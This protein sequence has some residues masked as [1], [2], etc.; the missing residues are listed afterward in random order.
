MV[1]SNAWGR[2]AVVALL[3]GA[4]AG[5]G[6]QD[7]PVDPLAQGV[8]AGPSPDEVLPPQ[9]APPKTR[10]AL[11]P[12]TTPAADAM[13]PEKAEKPAEPLQA[14]RRDFRKR[15]KQPMLADEVAQHASAIL[16]Y[17]ML[18]AVVYCDDLYQRRKVPKPAA[19]GGAATAPDPVSDS[20]CDG[21]FAAADHGWSRLHTYASDRSDDTADL[22]AGREWLGLRFGVFYRPEADGSVSVAV[23]F[24]GTDF[25]SLAD[26]YSN[27]R[28]VLPGHD[29]YNQVSDM[30][31]Q[32]IDRT[33]LD[34]KEALGRPIDRWHIVSTGHS[35]G[36]GLAQLFAYRS[37]EVE[38]AVVFDPSPVTAYWSCV[39]PK[40]LHCNVPV[41]RI[42]EKGEALAYVR[43]F[44]R[45]FYSLSENITE[46]EFDLLHGNI[47]ANHSMPR[48]YRQL[49]KE[50][51]ARPVAEDQF[52]LLTKGHPDCYC[53]K[54]IN[55]V[56]WK[57]PA[58]EQCEKLYPPSDDPGADAPMRLS[59]SELGGR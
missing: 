57:D 38:A 13:L 25:T 47:I 36:G 45:L 3:L 10:G 30:V 6:A 32:V 34:I 24:R 27:L 16:P 46:L 28:W 8:E 31:E 12:P 2:A 33:K 5:A 44:L 48:F 43:S 39:D 21:G 59:S 15:T 22:P 50:V 9:D 53:A 19:T 20:D 56:W 52:A 29:Q 4:A 11:D 1:I 37:A 58:K 49:S 41:W 14:F 35:L 40:V 42:Y 51:R 17:A 55:P 26:W 7:V 18:S 23:A 54:N